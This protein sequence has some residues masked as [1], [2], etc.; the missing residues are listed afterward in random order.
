[1]NKSNINYM[2]NINHLEV[3]LVTDTIHVTLTM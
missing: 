2:T 3:N 1:M